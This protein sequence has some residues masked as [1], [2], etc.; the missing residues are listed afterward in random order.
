MRMKST[1]GVKVI[2]LFFF[3]TDEDAKYN[4][5]FVRDNPSQLSLTL[6]SKAG[7]YP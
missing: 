1:P 3:V 2:K 5:V 7:A 4:K 6:A